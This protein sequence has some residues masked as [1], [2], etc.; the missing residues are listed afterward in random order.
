MEIAV[1]I[2]TKSRAELLQLHLLFYKVKEKNNW[3]GIYCLVA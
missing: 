2:T 3:P 1:D